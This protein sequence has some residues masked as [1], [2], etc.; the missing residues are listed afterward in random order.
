VAITGI[1]DPPGV[2]G[3]V[4]VLTARSITT[5]CSI[6]RRYCHERSFHLGS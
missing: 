3:A 5:Q 4:A 2:R 1:E 6:Y